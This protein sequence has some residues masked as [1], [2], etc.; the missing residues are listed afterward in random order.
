M[1]F[2]YYDYKEI[3]NSK[4]DE[5]ICK[6]MIDCLISD[7]FELFKNY[8][9]NSHDL[10]DFSYGDF[11]LF[12]KCCSRLK[13]QEAQKYVE[14]MI[15]FSRKYNIVI[16]NNLNYV[17]HIS[18]YYKN[19]KIFSILIQEDYNPFIIKE[20]DNNIPIK[21]IEYDDIELFKLLEKNKYFDKLSK[22]SLI[23]NLVEKNSKDIL[24]YALKQNKYF[25]EINFK[26]FE[27]EKSHLPKDSFTILKQFF[28]INSF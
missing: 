27:K 24:I 26:F 15:N 25:N 9:F 20:E 7:E 21:I 18:S 12:E 17:L 23:F 1:N 11:Y 2:K 16:Y 4:N 8:L 22:K 5:L 28:N 19:Y 13:D 6:A 3:L 14:L 10:F